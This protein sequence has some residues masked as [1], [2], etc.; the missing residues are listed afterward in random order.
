MFVPQWQILKEDFDTS[1]CHGLGPRFKIALAALQDGLYFPTRGTLRS[2]TWQNLRGDRNNLA[3]SHR[4]AKCHTKCT[5]KS[6]L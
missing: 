3:L 6:A 5:P 4:H 2:D 1:K